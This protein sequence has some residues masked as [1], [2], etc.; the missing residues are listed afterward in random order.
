MARRTRKHTPDPVM[1][2]DAAREAEAAALALSWRQ[3]N[4]SVE[5]AVEFDQWLDSL[6]KMTEAEEA[7]FEA[8]YLGSWERQAYVYD[9]R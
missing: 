1:E 9:R 6:P 5:D 8:R 7:E 2:W 3:A 4:W